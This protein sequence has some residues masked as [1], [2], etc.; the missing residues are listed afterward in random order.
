MPNPAPSPALPR[1]RHWPSVVTV[2]A[3]VAGLHLA[4]ELLIPF[5]LAFL[6]APTLAPPVVWLQRCRLPRVPAVVIVIVLACALLSVTTWFLAQQVTDLLAKLPEYQEQI[7]EKI[8]SLRGGM[9]EKA[10]EAVNKLAA[11]IETSASQESS[12]PPP[13]EVRVVTPSSIG[14]DDLTSS[15]GFLFGPLGTLAV[16][17]LLTTLLLL[18]PGD[19]RDRIVHLIGDSHVNLTTQA[20]SEIGTRVTRYLRMHMVLNLVHGTAV[21]VG[22][23]AFGVP[24]ALVWGLL[25]TLL[26]FIPYLGPLVAAA[27]PVALSLAV[28]DGWQWPL[29]VAFYLLGIETLSNN[30]LEPWLYGKT[31]GVSTLAVIASAVFWAWLWGPVGMVLAMPLTVALV[32]IGRHVPNLHFLNV[33]LGDHL[34]IE[35]S[36]RVYQRLLA[37]DQTDLN[38]ITEREFAEQKSFVSVCDTVLI[39]A[40][41]MA[42]FDRHHGALQDFREQ[43]IERAMRALVEDLGEQSRSLQPDRTADPASP[44]L[45]PAPVPSAEALRVL[46][47][48]AKNE[49]DQ[50]VGLMLCQA[51]GAAGMDCRLAS[52][53]ALANDKADRVGE[54]RSDIVCISALPPSGL[55]QSR[56]LAKRLRAR[57]PRLEIVV[58]LWGS[59]MQAD[60]ALR[61][62]R[63]DGPCSFTTTLAAACEQI[64]QFAEPWRLRQQALAQR[65]AASSP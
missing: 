64:R 13:Q 56:Y 52:G 41:A 21:G 32:V 50:I 18:R 59:D 30:V 1:P 58:G 37:M 40:L 12:V 29:L 61:Y 5:A 45:S 9:L 27:L 26:R 35:P 2:A 31:S 49:L 7:L 65:P 44:G 42:E 33:L 15:L 54:H 62:L 39:P 57:F 55:L 51:L 25:S 28:F 11:G 38:S 63:I 24:N 22:L 48:P 6:L 8:E 34:H 20:M 3:L 17:L 46:C 16:V 14:F 60:A 10:T 47:I 36:V 19:L 4:R 53:D 23:F 43:F